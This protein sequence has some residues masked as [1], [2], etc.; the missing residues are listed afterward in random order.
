MKNKTILIN[1]AFFFLVL[2]VCVFCLFAFDMKDS[3]VVGPLTADVS[4]EKL[5]T[6]D[7]LN[8]DEVIKLGFVGDIMLDRSV[9]KS[10][11]K[12]G[13][14]DYSF[15]FQK[16]LPTLKSFDW[17]FGN[18]EGPVSDKGKKVCGSIYSFQMATSVPAVLKQNNFSVVSIANNHMFDYC[19]SAFV[20]TLQNLKSADLAYI[21]GGSVSYTHLTLPTKRIV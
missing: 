20:D 3:F 11:N 16:I 21:G 18:L 12:N 9:K 8:Q 19:Y 10:I 5:D 15:P 1:T 6:V 7:D 17:L 13:G 4:I 14:G 2:L